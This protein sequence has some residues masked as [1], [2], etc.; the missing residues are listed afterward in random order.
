MGFWLILFFCVWWCLINR[1]DIRY[2]RWN[3]EGVGKE[4]AEDCN[5]CKGSQESCWSEGEDTKG[6]PQVWDYCYGSWSE[7]ICFSQEILLCFLISW[8]ATQY[9]N[10]SFGNLLQLTFVSFC[11]FSCRSPVWNLC[12]LQQCCGVDCGS[13][14]NGQL[15]PPPTFEFGGTFNSK[16]PLWIPLYLLHLLVLTIYEQ[17]RRMDGQDHLS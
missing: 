14:Y 16:D 15:G 13:L 6:E 11:I 3:S 8:I 1:S 9:P 4:R 5:S 2:R 17:P 12:K 10:V 7:L